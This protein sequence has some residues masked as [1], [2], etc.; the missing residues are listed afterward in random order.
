[1]FFA[2]EWR[3]IDCQQDDKRG[4]D[5]QPDR[6]ITFVRSAPSFINGRLDFSLWPP[7]LETFDAVTFTDN[8]TPKTREK[9][10]GR[11][12]GVETLNAECG[13]EFRVG[14]LVIGLF[15]ISSVPASMGR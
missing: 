10:S 2:K 6:Q 5:E 14:T 9:K 12:E 11:R 15:Q 7:T 13:F 3:P 4:V 1:V 8:G